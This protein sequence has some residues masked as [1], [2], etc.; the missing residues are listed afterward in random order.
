VGL[1]PFLALYLDQRHEPR[2]DPCVFAVALSGRAETRPK[3]FYLSRPLLPIPGQ[4]ADRDARVER[5]HGIGHLPRQDLPCGTIRHPDWW[6]LRYGN[7]WLPEFARLATMP[8]P[9]NL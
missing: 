2:A 4:C 1:L 6:L 8:R 9:A 5:L 7:A 3:E